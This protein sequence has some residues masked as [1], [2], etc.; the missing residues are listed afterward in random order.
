[1]V[2]VHKST[3]FLSW[4][5]GKSR[6]ASYIIPLFAD[7]QCYCEVFAGGAWLLFRKPPSKAEV[8]NDIKLDLVTLYRVVRLHLDEF[9]RYFKHLLV[10]RDE[11]ERFLKENPE[12]LTDIQRAVRFYYLTKTCYGARVHKPVFGMSTTGA[13]RLNLLRIE[14]ELSA[15]YLRLQRVVIEHLHYQEMIARYDRPHTL[16][17]LDPP[18]YGCEDYYGKNVFSRDDFGALAAQLAGIKGKF[19]MSINDVPEIRQI[20]S[21][22]EIKQVSTKYSVSGGTRQKAVSELVVANYRLPG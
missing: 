14:E 5:G 21:G 11:F 19:I 13:P 7:H 20:F 16:L 1:M 9:I 22:F 2:I 10:A 12:A 8:L 4:I 15:A 3:G 18:Y 17:Y 6:L